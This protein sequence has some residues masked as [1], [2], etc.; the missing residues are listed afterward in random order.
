LLRSLARV[1]AAVAIGA[2]LF[3]LVYLAV[4]PHAA[5][6]ASV[7]TECA[8]LHGHARAACT[9][10]VLRDLIAWIGRGL[11]GATVLLGAVSVAHPWLVRRRDDLVPLDGDT[12]LRAELAGLA[13]AG[14]QPEWLLAPY[15]Y[16]EG[17]RGFGLPWRPYV[18]I[19]VGLGILFRTD[20]SRFRAAVTRELDRLRERAV[21]ARYLA[22][23]S[24][25]TLTAAVP[26]AIP[27]H[28]PASIDKCLLGYWTE[29]PSAP[30]VLLPDTTVARVE[31]RGAIWSFT[32]DGTATLHLGQ[33]TIR[34]TVYAGTGTIR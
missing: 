1:F 33:E 8:A 14:R 3:T 32:G 9:E 2:A 11:I 16:T 30:P 34:S 22:A 28:P 24:L 12:A 27:A 21:G 10:P 6:L 4:P 26:A 23:G 15:A 18:R 20:R 13:E 17:G 29:E 31:R 19:D 7:H 5:I 25:V